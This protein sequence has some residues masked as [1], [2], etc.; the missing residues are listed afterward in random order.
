M[1]YL[2]GLQVKFW[3]RPYTCSYVK[4]LGPTL[5]LILQFSYT[6]QEQLCCFI[7]WILQTCSDICVEQIRC[8]ETTKLWKCWH[9][10]FCYCLDGTDSGVG[11][12][13]MGGGQ[14]PLAPSGGANEVLTR[15]D[16]ENLPRLPKNPYKQKGSFPF[17]FSWSSPISFS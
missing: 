14:P 12:L 7:W 13:G 17:S 8:W 4:K 5:N 11:N 6:V 3:R 2:M 16:V 15:M 10:N 9:T 1:C